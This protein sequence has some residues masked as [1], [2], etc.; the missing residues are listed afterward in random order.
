MARKNWIGQDD[1]LFFEVYVAPA[2][3]KG[4]MS[5][6]RCVGL[7]WTRSVNMCFAP[8]DTRRAEIVG[9]I[10]GNESPSAR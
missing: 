1:R 9:R 4:E 8:R 10:R 3:R 2:S 7:W 5:L 6:C